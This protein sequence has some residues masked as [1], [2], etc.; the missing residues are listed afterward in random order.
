MKK[1]LVTVNF[2]YRRN[3]SK[4]PFR[5]FG[6]AH[7]KPENIVNLINSLNN[8]VAY[9]NLEIYP[10]RGVNCSEIKIKMRGEWNTDDIASTLYRIK[11]ELKEKED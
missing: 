6:W 4:E 3:Y 9:G 1:N 5:D 2:S 8:Q 7:Y 11:N 10:I